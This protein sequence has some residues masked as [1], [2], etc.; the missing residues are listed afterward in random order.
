MREASGPPIDGLRVHFDL[1]NLYYLP[2]YLPVIEVLRQRGA[3]CTVLV[4]LS[5]SKDPTVRAG[6]AERVANDAGCEVEVVDDVDQDHR[7]PCDIYNRDKPDWIVF[8]SR[9]QQYEN[10]DPSISTAMLYHGIGV[11]NTYYHADHMQMDVRFVEGEYRRRALLDLFPGANLQAVGFAKLDP[12]FNDA[13]TLEPFDVAAHGLDAT[14]PTVLYAPTFYPSSMGRLPNDWPGQLASCN[15]IIKPHQFAYSKQKYGSQLEKLAHWQNY[16]NVHIASMTD[17]SIMPFFAS[18]E[19]LVSEASSALFEFA[20]LDKPVVWCDFLQLRW[21]HRGPF[22]YRLNARMDRTIDAFRNVGA[23][24]AR[25]A[26]LNTRIL[27]ELADPARHAAARSDCTREL[28]G[29][30]DGKA[31][32]RIVDYMAAN[33]GRISRAARGV[34]A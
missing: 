27:E 23:H 17:Y 1:T 18:S 29:L 28:I 25:P 32:E 15:L 8:G 19:L 31:S 33:T 11:K 24:A 7:A 26:Q 34:V 14:R 21:G 10:L 22:R 16:D 6:L 5:M 20:A 30:A 2:Q 9:F 12:L 4:Y 3:D 13:L